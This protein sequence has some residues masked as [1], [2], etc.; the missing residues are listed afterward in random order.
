MAFAD[1]SLLLSA[2]N[3]VFKESDRN[4]SATICGQLFNDTPAAN[5][6][7]SSLLTGTSSSEGSFYTMSVFFS[8]PKRPIVY[9]SRSSEPQIPGQEAFSNERYLFVHGDPSSGG[10]GISILPDANGYFKLRIYDRARPRFQISERAWFLEH[11][12]WYNLQIQVGRLN[13]ILKINGVEYDRSSFFSLP[14]GLLA[15]SAS[16]NLKITDFYFQARPGYEILLY[17]LNLIDGRLSQEQIDFILDSDNFNKKLTDESLFSGS[18]F[19][20]IYDFSDNEYDNQGI[21]IFANK[22]PAAA[23]RALNFSRIGTV[24]TK[25]IESD[26][27]P[28]PIVEE[29]DD[30]VGALGALRMVTP[31]GKNGYIGLPNNNVFLNAITASKKMSYSFVLK[32]DVLDT[33]N[34]TSGAGIMSFGDVDLKNTLLIRYKMSNAGYKPKITRTFIDNSLSDPSVVTA[35]VLDVSEEYHFLFVVDWSNNNELNKA[36]L[37]IDGTL[38]DEVS[39]NQNTIPFSGDERDFNIAF[40]GHTTGPQDMTI[41]NV[42]FYDSALTDSDAIAFNIARG[43]NLSLNSSGLGLAHYY[44]FSDSATLLDDS[45]GT[46]ALT[47]NS[48][49]S[50]FSLSSLD[51][52]GVPVPI[53]GTPSFQEGTYRFQVRLKAFGEGLTLGTIVSGSSTGN[54]NALSLASPSGDHEIFEI[55]ASSGVLR[56]VDVNALDINKEYVF[57]VVA[58]DSLDESRKATAVVRIEVLEALTFNYIYAVH[59]VRDYVTYNDRLFRDF[60]PTTEKRETYFKPISQENGIEIRVPTLQDEGDLINYGDIKIRLYRTINNGQDLFL[61]GELENKP[62]EDV[63]LFTDTFEDKDILSE[64]LIYTAN[65]TLDYEPVPKCRFIEI[66]NDIGYYAGLTDTEDGTKSTLLQSVP[67]DID[68]VPRS[69]R[70]EI[71][72]EITGLS[73]VSQSL[74]VF[75]RNRVYRV[76]GA[77]NS[78]GSGGMA[79][80][81]IDDTNGCLSHHSIVK[82][83]GAVFYLSERGIAIADAASVRLLT[84]KHLNRFFINYIANEKDSKNITGTYVDKENRIYWNISEEGDKKA[85]LVLDLNYSD[86]QLGSFQIIKG[87]ENFNASRVVYYKDYLLRSDDRGLMFFH[88]PFHSND[89]DAKDDVEISDFKRVPTLVKYKSVITDFGESLIQKYIPR[90]TTQI[91]SKYNYALD[92]SAFNDSKDI[93]RKLIPSISRSSVNFGDQHFMYGESDYFKFNKSD[94]DIQPKYFPEHGGLRSTYLEIMLSSGDFVKTSSK[95]RGKISFTQ[96]HLD[97][98]SQ[99]PLD[100]LHDAKIVLFLKDSDLRVHLNEIRA[101]RPTDILELSGLRY[102]GDVI[103]YSPPKRP[104]ADGMYS[105]VLLGKDIFDIINIIGYTIGYSYAGSDNQLPYRDPVSRTL[106]V[107]TVGG[108][109]SGVSD[110]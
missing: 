107:P 11:G 49:T 5:E 63:T 95:T 86:N 103:R 64:P 71:D 1:K 25:P 46:L 80:T 27:I 66:V 29:G 44:R 32:I 82:V 102:D 14:R 84:D 60:S 108:A 22:A 100:Q 39:L 79:D 92:I 47:T 13:T 38:Y 4:N 77:F 51:T 105:F 50:T 41:G 75:G 93:E 12:A 98:D 48:P 73:S 83:K 91:S 24:E 36:R 56:I 67:G 9:N 16:N 17:N 110:G 69:L 70:L 78:D 90:M 34:P 106:Q 89:L 88:S 101:K 62:N 3:R 76:D 45:K 68:S 53:A 61:I 35:P 18:F 2:S 43:I 94:I 40:G 97:L 8:I 52:L 58:T 20:G 42:G 26:V 54:Q 6:I 104:L 31:S 109:P 28:I 65:G 87:N 23:M 96:S 81:L 99:L 57:Q 7:F 21:P 74:I 37:Y 85:M 33:H 72:D 10:Y 59:Y 55:D 30:S 15:L 19:Y